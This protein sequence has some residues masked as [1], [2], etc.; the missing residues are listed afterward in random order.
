ML[1]IVTTMAAFFTLKV[2]ALSLSYSGSSTSNDTGAT[3]TTSGFTISNEDASKNICGYRF[4]VV[5]AAGTPKS[6]TKVA[7]VYLS[8][9]DIGTTAYSSG[10]RFIVS[11]GVVANKKQL[12]NGKSVKSNK[13]TQSCD[14]KSGSCGFYSTL[15]Q[16]P[17]SVGTWI[18]TSNNSY[19][20]LQ[21]IYVLCGTNLSSA[22]ESD[23]VLIEPIFWM[24]L[25][26]VG[27]AAT[28]TELAVY[29]AA[30]SGGD[31]YKGTDG[32]LYNA[33]SG[34]LW[35][36]SNYINREFPNALYVASKTDVYPAVSIISSG[37]YTY[38]QIIGNGLGCSVLTVKNVVTINEVKIAYHPN[39]GTVTKVEL[40]ASGYVLMDGVVYLHT[41]KHGNTCDP[42]NA[43]TFGLTR[44]GY[45]F[46]GWKVK[47][48][49]V[50]LDQNTSYTST[51]Y[52]QHND[53]SKT[54]AN[55]KTVYCYLLAVWEKKSYTN[56]IGHWARGFNGTGNNASGNAFN[57]RDVNFT[58]LYNEKF[59]VTEDEAIEFP[60]GF[61]LKNKFSTSY[62]SGTWTS[63]PFGT[64][65]TQGD[66]AMSLQFD[67]IPIEYNISYEL[68]G[69]TNDPDN[70]ATY[71]VLHGVALNNPTKENADFI[72][73]ELKVRKDIS[74]EAKTNNYKYDSSLYNIKPGVEY[75]IS[76]ESAKMTVGTSEKFT[77]L[78]YDSTAK[79]TLASKVMPFGND[80]EFSVSCP[81]DATASNDIR[82][83]IYA[84]IAGST[85]GNSAEYKNVTIQFESDSI[86]GGCTDVFSSSDDLYEQLKRRIIGDV[87]FIA[88]WDMENEILIV[89]IA[90]N[91]PYR[92]DTEV[93]TSYWIVNCGDSDVLP[94]NN[95]SV[96]I[97]VY[98]NSQL[99]YQS[100]K[101]NVVVPAG[102]KNL[103]YV[104][105][106]LPQSVL[107]ETLS[108]SFLT[109]INSKNDKS[110]SEEYEVI[111]Y[112]VYSTPD[113]QYEREAPSGFAVPTVPESKSGYAKW[114]EY[115]YENNQFIKKEYSLGMNG[116]DIVTVSSE[117]K[118][119]LKDRYLIKS[120]YPFS[121]S[122]VNNI[123]NVEGYLFPDTTAYTDLQ[124]I[125]AKFPEFGYKIGAGFCRTLLWEETWKF[126]VNAN[127]GN[128]H[129]IP[130]YYPDT[131][132]YVSFEKSDLWTPAGMLTA[133]TISNPLAID[134]NAYMDWYINH[135]K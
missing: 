55:T 114:W 63:Y 66:S 106:K 125:N 42:Y 50:T 12:A 65:I 108:I 22:T 69:G 48:T 16:A 102:D 123:C 9:L 80:I 111:P 83:L 105:W 3:A 84:G 107:S 92:E 129:F 13:T 70:P 87:E 124:Y 21:R 7:N 78:I 46:A 4:S 32:N 24:K 113:T 104:K 95:V 71:N 30:V 27:T 94:S 128:V 72:G 29:G 54:T 59:A 97:S 91:A 121:T 19:Q 81:S 109:I 8:N 93:V 119:K 100:K 82:I 52:A 34:T 135:G 18:K 1:L 90:P 2:N 10:Q 45:T 60:N 77:C 74:L 130:L 41:I 20:N 89:P 88:K 58:K 15:P 116:L 79:K 57:L 43:S 26:G 126:R 64:G 133:E 99:I 35:N 75:K 38:K 117:S 5:T 28:P 14:Y 132:Y 47:S 131:E 37:K 23:Y 6:G 101:D 33:G 118:D 53:S 112:T 36:L 56:K 39:G 115:E 51:V 67:Y 40:N 85:S 31:Q 96:R 86:N 76:M 98:D 25:A 17:G 120:G 110:V 62:I 49:G 11:S 122:F 127:Y 134:G 61:N 44:T 103:L 68:T 73:W